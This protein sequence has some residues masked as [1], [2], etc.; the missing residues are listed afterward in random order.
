MNNTE[1]IWILMARKL[2]GEASQEELQELDQLLRQDPHVNYSKE[3]LHDIW[4][5]QP[6]YDSQYAENKYKNLVQQI[7]NR[8]IDE[9]KF[10]QDDHF[11][12]G[13]EKLNS[14]KKSR[15]TFFAIGS[16]TLLLIAAGIFFFYSDKKVSQ[17]NAGEL[18]VKNEI[19]TKSGSKTNLVLPD[20][21]KVWLNSSSQLTY[22]KNYGN[23]LREVTLI[24]EAYFDVVKNKE[25][26]FVIHTA[27]MDIKVLGTAFNVKCYPGEKTTETSLV[28]GSIEVTLKDRLEKIMLKPNEKLVINNQEEAIKKNT[29]VSKKLILS[30]AIAEKPIIS[31]THL[32]FL[33]VDSTVIETAWVQNRL[34]FSSETFEEVVLK[35]ERWYNVKITFAEEALK[36]ERL[37]GNFEK[38]T[39]TD[40]LN[41]LQLTTRFSY[42]IKNNTI[43][44]YKSTIARK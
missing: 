7:K 41:A 36:E 14:D 6:D 5:M 26:P 9:G 8:G 17:I 1:H 15:K 31:V 39:V 43:N 38:E 37:T 4:R 18:N 42:N 24:G 27:K 20:G 30:K 34:V 40:A 21:T 16:V 44:I 3:I 22:E 2:S 28:R 10:I 25:K 29:T 23:K 35:M 33:P 11:I 32:T 12:N 19:S 13:E